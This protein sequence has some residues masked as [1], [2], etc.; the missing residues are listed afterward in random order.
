MFGTK[1]SRES[2]E[3]VKAFLGSGTQFSGKLLFSGAVRID[4]LFT[5]EI[6]G[7]NLLIS[8]EGSR[9]EGDIIVDN[10]VISGEVTANLTVREKIEIDSNG[11]LR[12]DVSAAVLVVQEG[13]ILE[14][15]CR[16]TSTRSADGPRLVKSE[17]DSE[18]PLDLISL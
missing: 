18:E 5:G 4:G 2:D 8:G 7:G 9:I 15:R 1:K 3:E 17:S 12:G 6:L 13:A 14:G 11:R 16:M 10:I